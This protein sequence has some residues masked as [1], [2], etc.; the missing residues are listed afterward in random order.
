MDKTL[1]IGSHVGMKAPDYYIGTV[2]EVISYGA[3]TFMFY[4]GAPQNSF[5]VPLTNLKIEEGRKLLKEAGFDE[6][7]IVVHAPY[8][9]NCA[10]QLND[11]NYDLAKKA[12]AGELKRTSSFGCKTLVLHPGAAVGQDREQCLQAISKAFSTLLIL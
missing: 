9:I 11:F 8:I 5:R 7:K 10:N 6:S 3:N 4:T 2:K 1:F 12:L